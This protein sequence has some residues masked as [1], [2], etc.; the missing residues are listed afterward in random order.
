VL[1]RSSAR[2][3]GFSPYAKSATFLAEM[4]GRLAPTRVAHFDVVE[5]DNGVWVTSLPT[6]I[7][8]EGP[9]VRGSGWKYFE[10]D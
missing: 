6:L 9:A 1:L 7:A 8:T 2:G 10:A 5:L 4:L 3:S